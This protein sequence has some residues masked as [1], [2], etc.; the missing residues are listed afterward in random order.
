[1]SPQDPAELLL[2]TWDSQELLYSQV[3]HVSLPDKVILV[4]K[5]PGV[6]LLAV[7]IGGVV[8]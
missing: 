6:G 5:D 1:M 3:N 8:G 7:L 4:P 2:D